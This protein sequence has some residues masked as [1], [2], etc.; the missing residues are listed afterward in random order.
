MLVY[1]SPPASLIVT[2]HS[3]DPSLSYLL[4]PLSP[5]APLGR[6]RVGGT[7]FSAIS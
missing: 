5:A 7:H 6:M 3:P 2:T 4:P 1:T